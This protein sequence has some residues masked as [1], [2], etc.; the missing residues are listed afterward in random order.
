[1]KEIDLEY[2]ELREADSSIIVLVYRKDIIGKCITN[3]KK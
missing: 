1:M 3:E 2:V